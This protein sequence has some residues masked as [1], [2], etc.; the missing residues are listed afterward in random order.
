LT[1][2]VRQIAGKCKMHREK[3]AS[4]PFLVRFGSFMY[5]RL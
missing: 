3:L 2:D 1:C 4:T 5:R